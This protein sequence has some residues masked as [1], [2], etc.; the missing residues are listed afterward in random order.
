MSETSGARREPHSG[1]GKQLFDRV[2]GVVYLLGVVL[3][4][5][6]LI[7]LAAVGIAA[8]VDDPGG[9]DGKPSA[10]DG[11][12]S[13]KVTYIVTGDHPSADL[14]YATGGGSQESHPVTVL[15][16]RETVTLGPAE[17]FYLSVQGR[18]S[19][20]SGTL[21]CTVVVGGKVI[22]QSE[23]SGD[24][25]STSCQGSTSKTPLKGT[26]VPELTPGAAAL[27]EELRLTKTVEVKDYK[28][29]GS[30]VLGR[31]T[32]TDARLSYVELGDPWSPSKAS[33]GSMDGFTR[34]QTF[35]AELGWEAV[36]KSGPVDGDAVIEATDKDRLR[37][38]AAAAQ[39][40]RR[41]YAYPDDET[42]IRDVASQPLR[43]S[44]H[45]AWVLVSEMHF[46]KKGVKSGYDL[47]VVVVVDTGRPMPSMLWVA[48]PESQKKRFADVNTLIESL[49][50]V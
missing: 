22:E 6:E 19:H 16:F 17:D 18:S 3:I 23:G 37:K 46:R 49:R 21:T 33:D 43:I 50:V 15:P 20:G 14:V 45:K 40:D 26:P 29:K 1:R 10:K 4:C 44:G 38:L 48:L 28:G 35:Q 42:V 34:G 11:A 8:A 41:K 2:P 13:V 25:P 39:D 32:D 30:R 31:V 5:F 12:K 27:P 36:A 9:K 24:Y 7:V 47:S